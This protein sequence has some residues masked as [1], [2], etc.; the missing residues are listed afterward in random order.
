MEKQILKLTGN[1]HNYFD[2]LFYF[3]DTL[4]NTTFIKEFSECSFFFDLKEKENISP[5][6]DF[7]HKNEIQPEFI[8]F[9]EDDLSFSH[10][11][12]TPLNFSARINLVFIPSKS[13]FEAPEYYFKLLEKLQNLV[14]LTGMNSHSNVFKSLHTWSTILQ[15]NEIIAT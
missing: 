3:F 9:S 4:K 5:L 8:F 11:T 1:E 10:K 2:N 13:D 15:D 6:L 12:S 7:L 14:I